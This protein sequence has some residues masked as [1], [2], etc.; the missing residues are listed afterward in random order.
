M[1]MIFADDFADRERRFARLGRGVEAEIAHRINDAPLHGL[2]TVAD[3]GQ[4]AVEH[5]VHRVVEVGAFGVVLERNLFV[6]GLQVHRLA[7]AEG[8]RVAE[9]RI[10]PHSVA[11]VKCSP[12]VVED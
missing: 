9:P 4:G 3:E 5:H 6:I 8:W 12:R 10:L 11:P 1:R 7:L 2:E